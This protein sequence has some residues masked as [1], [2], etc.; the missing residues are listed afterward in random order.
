MSFR[1]VFLSGLSGVLLFAGLAATGHTLEADWLQWVVG[2]ESR[3]GTIDGTATPLLGAKAGLV[4][5]GGVYVGGALYGFVPAKRIDLEERSGRLEGG[6]CGVELGYLSRADWAVRPF[7]Q[8]LLSGGSLAAPG[9]EVRSDP[10]L[11]V[12]LSAYLR[13]RVSRTVSVGA[14]SSYRRPIGLGEFGGLTDRDLSGFTGN[15]LVLF[16]PEW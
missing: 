5:P 7:V 12:E 10:F 14:G 4:S 1:K 8:L 16:G 11:V 13:V 2:P 9:T 6:Y 15:L 3:L